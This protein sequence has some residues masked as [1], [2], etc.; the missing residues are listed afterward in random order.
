MKRKLIEVALPLEAINRESAREK[1]IRHGHPSTL[2]LWWARRP[3]AACRAVLFAQLVDDPS[4]HPD[5]FPTEEDQAV[6]RKRL[7]GLIEQ[8]AVWEGAA[9]P[10]LLRSAQ[11][12]I[13]ASSGGRMPTLLDPF[14]G[15]GSIPLEAKRLGLSAVANDLNP[16]PVLLNTVMLD[17]VDRFGPVKP[18]SGGLASA[19][20]QAIAA[21]LR[22]YAAELEARVAKR[23]GHLY[24]GRRGGGQTL[25][26]F[27]ART[28]TCP[29]PACRYEVPLVGSWKAS[30]RRGSEASFR[31][32]PRADGVFDVE[33]VSGRAGEADGTMKRTG[34]TCPACGTSIPLPYVKAE[35]VAGRMGVR[36]LALQER[37]GRTRSFAP[38]DD[39]DRRATDVEA[40]ECDWLEPALSTHPQYMA[41]PR[42]GLTTF[43]DLFLPRQLTVLNAFVEELD[44]LHQELVAGL[45]PQ[46][47]GPDARTFAEGGTGARA[48]A[49]AVK[50][51]LALGIGRLVNRQSSLCIWNA[52]R[53]T[54]EQ[55][56]ARQ[57]YSMTWLFAEAN[58]FAGASGSFAGQIEFLAKALEALPQGSG[59]VEHGPAQG[60]TLPQGVVV[61]TDPPYYD[62]VPYAD[63]SDFFHVWHKRM[64]GDVLPNVFATVLSPKA[65]EL[66]ADQVRL[67]GRAAAK[68]FFEDG[69]RDV[70]ARL[71]SA[72]DP[73]VP[74]TV[75]YAFKQVETNDGAQ[76][77]TGWETMLEALLASGWS[78]SGTWPIRTEQPGGLRELGRN[79]LAS[80]VVIV[81]RLRSET[82]E[83]TTRRGLL[84][85]LK[86][87]LP[88]S[89]R[90][91]QQGSLAPVDL[92]QAAI[93]PGMAV[94]TRYRTV[95]EADGS[96]MTVRT[97]LGLINQV[98]DEVLSE[99]EGDLSSDTRFCVKWLSQFCWDEQPYGVAES[100]SKAV[101]TAVD[102]LVRG[103]V[104]WA[105]AGKARLVGLEELSDGWDPLTDERVSEW[106]VVVR[107]AKALDRDG[108][109][110]A[111]RLMALAGQRVD[112]DTT[113]ELAYLLYSVCEK[114]GWTAS[115]ALFNGLGT[116]W[117]DLSAAGRST[118]V[119][120]GGQ[121]EL[122]Y[123]DEEEG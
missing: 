75:Y 114:R 95:I 60:V 72:H 121:D 93:G 7:F 14:A 76:A 16:L 38:A 12:E 27:W 105:R 58:P 23:T 31:P 107:V 8:L 39:D 62:N 36:L 90:E 44:D 74:M 122:D 24:P 56:F 50:V 119:T 81:C 100:L 78:I 88:S 13:R 29:N 11:A 42:Y 2:H 5:R 115:A 30:A 113:K 101:A 120:S 102:G 89:L 21:D 104:F 94:F 54:V 26:Y 117:S 69:M 52:P 66:V 6:E 35:G 110:E 65:D 51:C 1:S 70:F 46:E 32:L 79:A 98:R 37:S 97:A 59:R 15:G 116:S 28:V 82:A 40:P 109:D 25:V 48:Y 45:P 71:A 87:E 17:L 43:A 53:Q 106:E 10:A 22:H 67:G 85:A 83:A 103:G 96:P 112:L 118:T 63:L 84:Q 9:D 41:P 33:V 18:V 111:A 57:A 99:Q 68:T 19:P 4:A 86:A 34:G 61:S 3:L 123:S 49:D 73:D 80:S 64:L 108:V 55:V 91:M 47:H 92:A 77:S 20:A